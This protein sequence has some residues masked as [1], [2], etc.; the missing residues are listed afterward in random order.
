MPPPPPVR[1]GSPVEA[2]EPVNLTRFT[3]PLQRPGYVNPAV[4][5]LEKAQSITIDLTFYPLQAEP[6]G[7]GKKQKVN[8]AQPESKTLR[9]VPMHDVLFKAMGSTGI[10]PLITQ[11]DMSFEALALK[12]KYKVNGL[13]LQEL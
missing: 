8:S 3:H 1:N 2:P 9:E 7:K 12:W 13:L 5:R 6:T 11:K 10:M 4:A